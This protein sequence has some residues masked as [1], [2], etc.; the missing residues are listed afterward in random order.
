M[1]NEEPVLS[2]V[3]DSPSL[4]SPKTK[5][6]YPHFT[7]L[8]DYTVDP[9]WEQVFENCSRGK[10]PKN[11]GYSSS[12]DSIWCKDSRQ[13]ETFWIKLTGQPQTDQLSLKS[14][15]KKHLNLKSKL[16]K[17][18]NRNQFNL[19]KQELEQSYTGTWKEI[20]KKSVKDA[21][22]RAFI[23]D[24][25]KKHSLNF[26]ETINVS[27]TIRLG[28]LFNWISA[29]HIVYDSENRSIENIKNLAYDNKK[30][31]FSLDF[32]AKLAKREY[33]LQQSKLLDLWK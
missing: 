2:P 9:Y 19:L 7:D 8:L 30:R 5:L 16:D 32:P 13:K 11:S 26:E 17:S 1:V 14:F 23:L 22:I 29:D 12:T 18:H 20:K 3:P 4:N 24:L 28:L 10:F 21:L 31:T 15:F 25:K 33:K 27:R 6:K